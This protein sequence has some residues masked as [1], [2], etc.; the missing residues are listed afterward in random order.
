M[1]HVYNTGKVQIGLAYER[2][3]HFEQSLDME[4]LQRALLKS[5]RPKT[6]KS[7]WLIAISTLAT[8]VA[9]FATL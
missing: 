3:Q 2:P 4:R 7:S 1:K 5:S 6:A 8:T 9:I